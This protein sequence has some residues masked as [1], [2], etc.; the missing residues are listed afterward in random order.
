MQKVSIL[1]ALG[2]SIALGGCSGKPAKPEYR[3]SALSNLPFVYKMTVQQGNIVTEEMVD[4]LETGMT[5]TQVRYLLGTPML[6]DIFH[7]D[8]WFYTYTIRRGHAEMEKRPLV[9]YFNGDQMVRVEGHILPDSQRAASRQ[10][11]ELLV[12][13]PD[14]DGDEGLFKKA[15]KSVGLEED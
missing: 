13:V 2:A 7:G 9:V 3:E 6:T 15:L 5:R 14:W 10:P 8:R 4:G 1:L 12:S 11:E